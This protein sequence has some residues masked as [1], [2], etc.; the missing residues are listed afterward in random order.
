MASGM[1]ASLR[2]VLACASLLAA[3]PTAAFDPRELLEAKHA[4]LERRLFGTSERLLQA[5]ILKGG[6]LV[7]APLE[8]R[9]VLVE[10][11]PAGGFRVVSVQLAESFRPQ[12][13]A[14]W[15]RAMA[16]DLP[17][18]ELPRALAALPPIPVTRSE[19]P[20]RAETVALLEGAWRAILR[21]DRAG[22]EHCLDRTPWLVFADP[23]PTRLPRRETNCPAGA[24]SGLAS[25]AA[26]LEIYGRTAPNNRDGIEG[27]MRAEL[28]GL[29]KQLP[30]RAVTR[31]PA[32]RPR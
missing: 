8:D 17:Y 13:E 14:V 15:H 1:R 30:Q 3:G 21:D 16:G 2:A 32:A 23:T 7:R 25:L 20:I 29:L 12:A 19:A 11:D 27:L 24:A 22:W 10:K 5:V 18:A 28:G 6:G 9:G 4:E 31:T 26:L